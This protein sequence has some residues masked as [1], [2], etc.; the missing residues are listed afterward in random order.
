MEL[1]DLLRQQSEWLK[2]AGPS[3][4]IVM[5]SRV[6]LA[7]NLERVPFSHW[8]NKK[9]LEQALNSVETAILESGCLDDPISVRL[10]GV[11]EVDRQFLVERHL[12]SREHGVNPDHKSVVFSRN[13]MLSIM[14]NEEDHLRIQAL[15][16]GL[17]IHQAWGRANRADDL[18]SERLTFA[19]RKEFGYLTCC[20]TNAGTGIRASVMM[21]LP[22]LV[23]TKQINK[24]LQAIAKL[25]LT[26]RGLYGEG[27]EA[28]GNFFQ[29]SN[30]FTLGQSEEEI[31]DHLQRVVLQVIEH[32]QNARRALLAQNRELLEDR[33]WRAYGTLKGA[34]IIT[35]HETIDL[36][37][38]VRLGV[39]MGLLKDVERA[40][41]NDLFIMTQPAHLQKLEGKVLGA[42]ERDVKRAALVRERL[43]KRSAG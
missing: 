39:D 28:S 18:L 24:V 11:E 43:T 6:R 26:S 20:P 19:F 5:S 27:T 30:Q 25:N 7:R 17:S 21:H 41:L 29:I 22:S 38:T 15:Q 13:E 31:I 4:E 34:R 37:S 12:I 8:A 14:V 16:S 2:G 10:K 23:L 1:N 42:A 35:S 40:T 9:Q 3:A 32:E 33:I 36:L